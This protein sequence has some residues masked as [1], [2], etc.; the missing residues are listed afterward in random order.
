MIQL[1]NCY[2]YRKEIDQDTLLSIYKEKIKA[3][4]KFQ[5]EI[6]EEQISITEGFLVYPFIEGNIKNLEYLVLRNKKQQ[7]GVIDVACNLASREF[8]FYQHTIK[9][10]AEENHPISD[11]IIFNKDVIDFYQKEYIKRILEKTTESI[12]KRHNLILTEHA[13]SID[14]S[15]IKTF[16]NYQIK[17][18]LEEVYCFDYFSKHQKTP[19]KSIFSTLKNDFYILDFKKSEDFETFFKLYKRPIVPIPK[20]YLDQYYDISFKTYLTTKEELKYM[21]PS[22]LYYKIKKHVKYEEY[23]KH[24]EYLNQLIFYFKRTQYLKELM[25]LGNEL[26]QE[27]FYYYLTLKHKPESGYNLAKLVL[28]HVI[29]D[30]HIR[31]YEI[32]VRQGNTLAKKALFEHYSEP[33]SYNSY[34]IKRYS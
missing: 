18:Y 7:T 13:N 21:K 11:Y 33:R 24:N 19:F 30:N 28:N 3:N 15:P 9:C 29:E 22:E 14:I 1:E 27:I 10:F 31:L 8:L 20:I 16:D 6:L 2:V 25:P 4:P 34:Y 12:C 5:N 17:Y 26:R 32:S 23:S